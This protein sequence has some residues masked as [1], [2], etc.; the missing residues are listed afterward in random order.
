MTTNLLCGKKRPRHK[1]ISFLF[2]TKLVWEQSSSFS[3]IRNVENPPQWPVLEGGELQEHTKESPC[4][5]SPFQEL[6]VIP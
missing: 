2:W 5:G 3:H 6:A 1:K 4:K